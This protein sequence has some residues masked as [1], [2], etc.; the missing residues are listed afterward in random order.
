[1]RAFLLTISLFALAAC[2]TD[3][4]EIEAIQVSESACFGS[5]PIYELTVT[6]DDHYQLDGRRFTR[7]NGYSE[8][9]LAPGSYALMED[10]LDNANFFSLPETYTFANPDVCPGPQL[11]DMPSITISYTTRR[12]T[13]TVTWYQG[14]S[15]PVM[16]DLRDGLRD[17]FGYEEIVLPG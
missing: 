5:C 6:P 4:N 14:C 3:N 13:H 2:A 12:Q 16:R 7:I 1:M 8:G 17:A 15:A 9:Q 10:L 11:S